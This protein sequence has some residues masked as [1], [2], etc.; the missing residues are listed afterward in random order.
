MTDDADHIARQCA[1][2]M[3]ASD[4]A[5]QGLGM[6][7]DT[8]RAGHAVLSM[9]VRDDM[10]NGHGTCH[11]GFIFTLA[12]SAFAFPATPMMSAPWPSIVPSPSL[13][14]QCAAMC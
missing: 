8:V 14:L 1:Q 11:G 10:V 12:D 5:S 13:H 2:A 6:T 4:T 9:P 3:W 7:L